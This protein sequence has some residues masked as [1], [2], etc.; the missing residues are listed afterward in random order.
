MDQLLIYKR[1]VT[2]KGGRAYI[3]QLQTSGARSGPIMDSPRFYL[4]A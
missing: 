3:Y 4:T 2:G 1:T